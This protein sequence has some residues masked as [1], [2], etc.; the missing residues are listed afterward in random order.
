MSWPLLAAAEGGGLTDINVTTALLTWATFGVTYLVL[1]KLAWPQLLA[2]LEARE[3]RIVE[4]L[5]RAD[6]A[7]AKARELM[8]RRQQ[9]LDEARKEAQQFLGAARSAAEQQVTELLRAAQ[10]ELTEVRERAKEQVRREEAEALETLKL[11]AATLAPL[12]SSRLIR[13]ELC[14]D[15]HRRLAGELIDDLAASRFAS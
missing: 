1:R 15:E 12:V 9:V 5:R 7:D 14:S 4:G 2:R 6:E 8:A 3:Q 11:T 10:Q 13:R